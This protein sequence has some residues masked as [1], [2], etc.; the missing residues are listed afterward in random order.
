MA[1]ASFAGVESGVGV[2]WAQPVKV[3]AAA[4][5]S[6]GVMQRRKGSSKRVIVMAFLAG[7]SAR[8]LR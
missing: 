1:V 3:P 7:F 2:E 4:D 6:S 8:I 5:K